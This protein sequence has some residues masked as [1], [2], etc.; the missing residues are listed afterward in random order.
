VCC[1]VTI[2]KPV[3]V[4]MNF[5]RLL[6]SFDGEF[7]GYERTGEGGLYSCTCRL[8]GCHCFNRD[9]RKL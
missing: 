2:R 9:A 4:D 7:V 1:T 3:V 8:F 5:T 6:G